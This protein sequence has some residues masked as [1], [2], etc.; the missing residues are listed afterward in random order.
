MK[1]AVIFTGGTIGSQI[2]KNGYIGSN[3][4]T[5]YY[6]LEQYRKLFGSEV[7][8]EAYEPYHILSENLQAENLSLL[9][10]TI[11]RILV[12]NLESLKIL[13]RNSPA[14]YE[15]LKLYCL[16]QAKESIKGDSNL[17]K[18]IS[19]KSNSYV[20][21]KDSA[22]YSSNAPA[23]N[24]A[25]SNTPA[26]EKIQGIIVTH[27]TDSL[28][29]TAAVLQY[30]FSYSHIPI[31]LVSSDYV[32]TEPRANGLTN[33]SHAVD[34]IR[35]AHISSNKANENI[36]INQD[37]SSVSGVFVSYCN[38]GGIPMI[39]RGTRLQNVITYSADVYSILDS[40]Y[41][42]FENDRFYLNPNY[43]IKD[44]IKS[45][46]LGNSELSADTKSIVYL[47]AAPGLS[48]P[49]LT[50]QHKAVLFEGYHSGT[51]PIDENL[52]K[53]ALAAA[54]LQIPIYLT[55]L[56]EDM[57]HYETVEQYLKL[58]I[59]PLVNRST[60]SQYCKLWL[61]ISNHMDLDTV[62]NTSIAE[63]WC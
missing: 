60:I 46:F 6:L 50:K 55:G 57:D 56:T 49:T 8:F 25:I 43:K 44:K 37:N 31:V 28:A 21:A 39:H 4:E 19:E 61:A 58:G 18:N 23:K 51:I 2:Q 40:W 22:I 9:I 1:L 5:N 52:K 24:S 7:S 41:G 11:K 14:I 13:Q 27:G 17:Q 34:F 53:F 54:S 29:Y 48:Y 36:S 47:K 45:P 30:V 15:L 38:Q 26:D 35:H 42:K 16:P 10:Y 20:P 32:L 3:A 63:D 59:C 33:F 62:M 12:K